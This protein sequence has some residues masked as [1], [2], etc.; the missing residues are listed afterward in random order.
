M[1]PEL[2]NE[3][4]VYEQLSGLQGNGIPRFNC[5][6]FLEDVL[7]CIGVSICGTVANG[8]TEQ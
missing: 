4:S 6:G 8:F 5:H 1:L 3:V 2:L 7:Y